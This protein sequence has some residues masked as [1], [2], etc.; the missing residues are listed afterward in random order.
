MPSIGMRV[1]VVNMYTAENGADQ[2][3]T[4]VNKLHHT[5]FLL[6]GDHLQ[7]LH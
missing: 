7:A 2:I 4:A 5:S 6:K 1:G 3:L